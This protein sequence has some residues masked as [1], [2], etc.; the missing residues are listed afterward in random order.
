MVI[1]HKGI[2]TLARKIAIRE[3]PDTFDQEKQC[4]LRAARIF[5]APSEELAA[6][7]ADEHF[8]EFQR[9]FD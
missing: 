8:E 1:S 6:R 9:S 3:Q 2:M 4:L 7:F 5:I